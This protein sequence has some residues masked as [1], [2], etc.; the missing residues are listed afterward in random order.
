MMVSLLV[1]AAML[2]AAVVPA[3]RAQK[4][5]EN[6]YSNYAPVADKGN[7]VQKVLTKEYMGQP[8]WYVVQFTKGWVIVSAD[9]AVRPILG[10]SFDDGKIT[11]DLSNMQNPFVHRFG[12]YDRQIVHN[13]REQ[14]YA[15]SKAV[16]EWKD[17]ENNVFPKATKAIVVGALCDVNYG[18]GWPWD[19]DCPAGTP[20]GCVATAMHQIMRV[21]QGPAGGAGSKTY[22]D[23]SGSTTGVHSVN[24]ATA[25]Y[26]WNLI[27]HIIDSGDVST[28]AE[29]DELAELSYHCGVSVEMDYETDGSGAFTSDVPYALETYFGF[30]TS[31]AYTALGT[32]T[33]PT[34]FSATIWAN[35]ADER[36]MEFAGYDATYGGHAY[37]LDGRTDDYWY[38]FNWGWDGAY[39]GWYQLTALTPGTPN[40]SSSQNAVYNIF[41]NGLQAEWPAPENLAGVITNGEDVSLSWDRPTGVKYGTLT[42]YNIYK[43]DVLIGNVGSAVTAFADND[44]SQGVYVYTVKATYTTPD[45]TSLISNAY[46]ATIVPDANFPVATALTAT[47]MGRTS[48]DLA[49]VKPYVG[50]IYYSCDYETITLATAWKHER[51]IDYPPTGRKISST[52][53]NFTKADI[54][55][56]WFQCDESSFGDPQYI[57]G[58][59]YSMAI[60][61]T[62]P[63]MTWA[64]SPQFTIDNADAE[65]MY[66]HWTTGNAGSGWLTNSYVNLYTGNFTELNP[67]LVLTQ[68]AAYV[69][70]DETTENTYT[71]Q[72]VIDLSAYTGTYRI[73][74]TYD[75]TDGYQMAVDDIIIGSAAKKSAVAE[76]RAP[77]TERPERKAFG[78]P[79]D[80]SHISSEPKADNPTAYQIY[81]NGTLATTINDPNTL[82]W[83]DTSFDDGWNEYFIKTVYPTGT[84][85]ACDRDQA[86]IIEN[87]VPGFLEGVLNANQTDVDLTW[88]APLHLPPHWFGYTDDEFESYFDGI[89]GMTGTWA[90]RRT[91]FQA[92]RLGLGY[93]YPFTI[94]SLAAAFYE[95]VAT[96]PWTDADFTFDIY[97]SNTAGTADSV[98]LAASPNQTA[99]SGF[100]TDYALASQLTMNWGWYVCVNVNANG[101]PSSFVN[102]VDNSSSTVYY[103]GDG[104]Y[105]AG[106][107][108][109]TF[110]DDDG[111]WAIICHGQASAPTWY[112][113][114]AEEPVEHLTFTPTKILEGN[115][116]PELDITT[117]NSKA[118][119]Q[120]NVYRNSGLVGNTTNTY[121]TDAAAPGGD[122]TYEITAVYS[123]PA[124]ESAPCASVMVNVPVSQTP[125]TPTNV[126]TSVV[127]GQVVVNWDDMSG[128]TSYNVYS[129]ANPYGTYTLL[130]NV[131]VSQYTYTGAETKMFFQITSSNSKAAAPK[132]I[133]IARPATR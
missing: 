65:L 88:Y 14:G 4:V 52:R 26:D 29:V 92:S 133:E 19:D 54:T 124:G 25:V 34:T 126:V 69:G 40:F 10:Y 23:I 64:F 95:D 37:V 31:C 51:T 119:V 94:D 48:I 18:Q 49:W 74:W 122:N 129:S 9:D 96:V 79:A 107:Y 47:T 113:N 118:F 70:I 60:G 104:T 35:L 11:E 56:G 131:A 32:I 44:L 50:Q 2:S 1:L 82:T 91:L 83:S 12:F 75:Y 21:H 128:A 100:W 71:S 55:D 90:R 106:W 111:D 98:I 67:S 3:D 45:G 6:Y 43:N 17:I 68:I 99:V 62:A 42:G 46:Q 24:F 38:H 85:I 41:V 81:R 8:T 109:I 125:D 63:D 101:T 102:V 28:Q 30:D 108:S 120:Y 123:S 116:K 89:D 20:V 115:V 105:A 16:A 132:T 73:A 114:K 86:F 7:T 110:G 80:L 84:S 78:K 77:L 87:P 97:T 22:N 39:N 121:Y 33:D 58:G 59:T 72:V 93:A 53:D 61:Y 27:S 117:Q 36:P 76:G 130:T 13:V 57:H 127:G 5:A 103:G 15:D 112:Y 66:W